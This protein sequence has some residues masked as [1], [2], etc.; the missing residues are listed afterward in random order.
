MIAFRT[1]LAAAC[2][3]GVFTCNDPSVF[4]LHGCAANIPLRPLPFRGILARLTRRCHNPQSS[5]TQ[6][7]LHQQFDAVYGDMFGLPGR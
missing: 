4:E 1:M 5:G 7:L 6:S 3:C 2:I